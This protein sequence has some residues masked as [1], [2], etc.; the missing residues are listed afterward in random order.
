MMI[1]KIKIG[2]CTVC[3]KRTVF[4]SFN[5]WLRESYKCIFCRSTPRERAL[6]KVLS[7]NVAEWK[8]KKIHE[9]SPGG[10]YA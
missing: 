1:K 3:Q 2:Y 5:N 7:E 9:S 6:M 8:Y 4:V 10:G